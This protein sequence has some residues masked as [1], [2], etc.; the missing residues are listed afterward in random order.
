MNVALQSFV[1]EPWAVAIT[2]GQ[3]DNQNEFQS[4]TPTPME[5]SSPILPAAPW[6]QTTTTAAHAA[7]DSGGTTP[8]VSGSGT[9][10][11]A[12]VHGPSRPG[13]TTA[14]SCGGLQLK[15]VDWSEEKM[16]NML[17]AMD[18]GVGVIEGPLQEELQRLQQCVADIND[19]PITYGSDEFL[20]RFTNV[21]FD[22]KIVER[23]DP[24]TGHVDSHVHYSLSSSLEHLLQATLNPAVVATIEH[25]LTSMVLVY[26]ATQ[27]MKQMGLIGTPEECGLLPRG[28]RCFMEKFTE[29]R[30]AQTP[31]NS[32]RRASGS[33]T[34][35]QQHSPAH[36]QCTGQATVTSG[37]MSTSSAQSDCS[38]ES[39]H[40]KS[41]QS[42]QFAFPS[43]G[44]TRHRFVRVECTF[45]A[46]DS[47]SVIDLLQLDNKHV[48]LVLHL[49]PP[50]TPSAFEDAG[51]DTSPLASTDAF[52]LHAHT[53]PAET[54][55]D[56]LSALDVGLEN[57]S[58]ALDR[59][60][61]LSESGSSLLFSLT[62]YT[63]NARC[64]TMHVLCL[65]EDP[66]AQTWLVSTVQARSEAIRV[67]E[68]QSWAAIQ[69]TPMPAPLHHHAATMLVPAL[70]FGNVFMSV[71]LCVYNSMTALS[72]L[73]RDLTFASTGYRQ[74]TIPRVTL[75]SSRRGGKVPLPTGWE[76]HFTEEGRRYFT[77]TSTLATTCEDPRFASPEATQSN[78]VRN[79]CPRDL[80]PS[81][82]ELGE[83][84][85]DFLSAKLVDATTAGQVK[86]DS[87]STAPPLPDVGIVVVDTNG[88]PRVVLHSRGADFAAQLAQEYLLREDQRKAEEQLR[89]K[90][91]QVATEPS[92]E[93]KLDSSHTSFNDV[94]ASNVP[95]D[96]PVQK[97]ATAT[98]GTCSSCHI[99]EDDLA[100]DEPLISLI[101]VLPDDFLGEF[102]HPLSDHVTNAV[103]TAKFYANALQHQVATPTSVTTAGIGCSQT[104]VDILMVSGTVH[105]ATASVTADI[106]SMDISVALSPEAQDLESLVEE[107]TRFFKKAYESERRVKEL[108]GEV[109]R[110]RTEQQRQ[111]QRQQHRRRRQQRG[112]EQSKQPVARRVFPSGVLE[113]VGHTLDQKRPP[114]LH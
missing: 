81:R 11:N 78:R 51:D 56:A 26:G 90:A 62:A 83:G 77:S 67:G 85:K 23:E 16:A 31:Q 13:G 42:P 55:N 27:E 21:V 48:E 29:R 24:E 47:S 46:F 114:A 73:N 99:P 87:S 64:A 88:Q 19:P 94:V 45:I 98:T 109:A 49:E 92:V 15:M 1:G 10:S 30:E 61:L 33:S 100:E 96:S 112:G 4:A 39:R 59:H 102:E 40:S 20:R 38:E 17:S 75:V 34:S 43:I 9:S 107:F 32:Q 74:R 110:L 57:W 12:M 35:S 105:S 113:P 54:T 5:S 82:V 84:D 91:K 28:I 36:S 89:L 95:N 66:A 22:S 60:S 68:E 80:R 108:E 104:A 71:L 25:C 52:V 3:E 93:F 18:G 50:P 6:G 8:T 72:R 97:V 37:T 58:R 2:P 101:Q 53:I 7:T 76:E 111:R 65:A 103:N 106:P 44:S 41:R 63:D 69:N 70:C 79:G 14:V 86:G